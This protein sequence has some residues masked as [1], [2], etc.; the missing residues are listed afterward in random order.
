[1]RTGSTVD[2]YAAWL[3]ALREGDRRAA[4]EVVRRAREEGLALTEIY[5]EI[6]QPALQEIG[7]LWQENEISVADEHLATAITQMAMAQFYDELFASP[8]AGGPTLIGACVDVERHEVGLRMLC[9]LLEVEGW[10]TTYLGA[11][12]PIGGLVHMVRDRQ[13]DVVALSAALM[14]HVSRV[15]QVVAA[16]REG[17]GERTPTILVGGRAFVENPALAS[18]VGAD[19]TASTAAGA[20]NLLK[21]RFPA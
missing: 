21:E 1:M 10:D 19:L 2:L 6:F 15:A 11:A 5:L 12:V 4:Q 8:S 20:V 9:D 3:A 13:P 7:R 18:G 14:P 17:L 16:L